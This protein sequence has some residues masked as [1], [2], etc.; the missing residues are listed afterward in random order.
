[1][2]TIPCPNKTT[3]NGWDI[4]IALST[5]ALQCSLLQPSFLHIKGNQAKTP[6]QPLTFIKQYNIDCDHRAKSYTQTMM[7]R[8]TTYGN[9]AIPAA[10]PHL[11]IDNK[12]ICQNLMMALNNTMAF[13]SY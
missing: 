1:M 11:F 10:Q 13:P 4:Y 8:S 9:P 3:N 7:K 12:F 2:P 6:N 5:L